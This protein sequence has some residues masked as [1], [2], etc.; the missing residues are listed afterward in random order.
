[1]SPGD[2]TL[3]TVF[4]L[5]VFQPDASS[6]RR[7]PGKKPNP[8]AALPSSSTRQ[9]I[10]YQPVGALIIYPTLLVCMSGGQS[11]ETRDYLVQKQGLRGRGRSKKEF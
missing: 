1:M 6:L 3:I 10:S 2:G 7:I 5:E 9:H 11:G 4:W 8:T